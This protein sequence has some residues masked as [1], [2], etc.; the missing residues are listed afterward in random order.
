MVTG[1]L[2]VRCERIRCCL[3]VCFDDGR[4]EEDKD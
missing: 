2:E 4:M 1:T 3:H